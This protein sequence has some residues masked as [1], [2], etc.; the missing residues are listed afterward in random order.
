MEN[1][2]VSVS[3]TFKTHAPIFK[4]LHTLLCPLIFLFFFFSEGKE[5]SIIFNK[6]CFTLKEKILCT[7]TM[8]NCNIRKTKI[9]LR[10]AFYFCLM[11]TVCTCFGFQI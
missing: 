9:L 10:V 3:A 8:I 4:I 2:S 11:K 5:I 7:Q 6:P 1:F